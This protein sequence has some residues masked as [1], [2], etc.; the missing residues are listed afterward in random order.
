MKRWFDI[1]KGSY[2]STNGTGPRL[3]DHLIR[4]LTRDDLWARNIWFGRPQLMNPCDK[5][6]PLPV[7]WMNHRSIRVRRLMNSPL[8]RLGGFIKVAA[9]ERRW[10][11]YD[12]F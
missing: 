2:L 8:T 3:L 12:D 4:D 5:P 10:D 1:D 6:L 9:D 7:R 11:W